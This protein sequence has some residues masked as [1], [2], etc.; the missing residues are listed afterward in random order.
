M[1]SIAENEELAIPESPRRRSLGEYLRLLFSGYL[2]GSGNVVPGVSG[3]TMA[4]ILGVYEEL[5]ESLRMAGQPAFYRA[6]FAFDVRKAL[7]L[8]H[9]GF[10][11]SIIAGAF[12]AII[13]LVPGLEWMLE[14]QPVIIWSFF[15]GLILA[16]VVVVGISIQ[17]WTIIIVS[18]LALGAIG[19]Y[20]LVGM[21]PVQTPDAWWFLMLSGALAICAMILPGISGSFILVMLGKYEYFVRAVNDRDLVAIFWA[22]LG[23]VIGLVSFA[24][25]LSWLFKNYR[26]ATI[27][28][29]T[30]FMLGSLRKVWPWKETLETITDR[31]GDVVPLIERNVL[32][33][34]QVDGH[35]NMQILYAVISAL[36]GLALVLVI[37]RWGGTEASPQAAAAAETVLDEP[38]EVVLAPADGDA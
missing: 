23:A 35:F 27:A 28:V 4:F 22:G 8:I 18:A 17:R 5:V 16:S 9:I 26:D 36:L 11:I 33:A 7:R 30:G 31:H 29:L 13:T 14:Y 19:A 12:L 24:Q 34:L 20:F 1:T 38:D 21:V 32:P 37:E 25:V 15:F 3:G 6:L 10:L 2:I